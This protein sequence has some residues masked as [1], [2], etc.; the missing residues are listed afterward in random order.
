M[1]QVTPW[2]YSSTGNEST[3]RATGSSLVSL[4]P[5]PLPLS[6]SLSLSGYSLRS[7]LN[8][9]TCSSIFTWLPT[10][11]TCEKFLSHIYM[12]T[13]S[14]ATTTKPSGGRSECHL[15]RFYDWIGWCEKQGSRGRGWTEGVTVSSRLQGIGECFLP[16][17][18]G[19]RLSGMYSVLVRSLASCRD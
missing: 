17:A 4:L 8:A 13:R 16:C 11:Q 10:T 12:L 7:P 9:S 14:P 2:R 1:G 3:E 6:L 15:G 19:C 5:F 18:G